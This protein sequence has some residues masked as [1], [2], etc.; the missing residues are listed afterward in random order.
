MIAD[1]PIVEE[2]RRRASELSAQF[3]DDLRKYAEHLREIE[4][5]YRERVVDQVT[6]VASVRPPAE[7]TKE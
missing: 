1:S 4:E 3:D 5:R 2:V 6:V 7:A